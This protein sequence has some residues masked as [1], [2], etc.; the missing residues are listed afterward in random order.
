MIPVQHTDVAIIGAG[1]LGLSHAHAFAQR[2]LGVTV[3]ERS[4]APLGASIR[5]FGMVLVTGQPPG[6]MLALAQASRDLWLDWA[7]KAGLHVR[8][9]GSLLF[10]RTTAE[11]HV[12]EAFAETRAREAGYDVDLL[13]APALENLYDGR[14]RHHRAALHG[15]ADLQLFSREAL[16][17]LVDYLRA[18]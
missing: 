16:P 11:A 3:F 17:A 10:A 4:G 12:L 5:N 8:Q 14:F 13:G 6:P 2:G 1:I 15:R 7:A 18:S 9:S